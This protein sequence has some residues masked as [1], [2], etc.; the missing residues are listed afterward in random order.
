MFA[1]LPLLLAAEPIVAPVVVS[2]APERVA[3]S[4][5]RDPDRGSDDAIDLSDPKG[6]AVVSEVRRVTLPPGPVTIRFEGVASG[7]LPQTA[8]VVGPDTAE[9]NRD[10]RLL[11]QRGLLDAFTG[12]AMTLR[13]TDRATGRVTTE[14]AVLRSDA[15][16]LI[17]ETPRGIEAVKCSGLNQ[18]LLA[19]RLPAGL[20]AKPVLSVLT[21]DQPGG[22]VEVTLTY[23]ATR[24]D[25][26]ANYV[27]ELAPD[28]RHLDLLGWLTLAS[29][30]DTS[31]ADAN[32]SAIAGRVNKQ[33]A[34]EEPE[35]DDGEVYFRCWPAGTT[36]DGLFEPVPPPPPAPM[37][38][39]G[40][41][42]GDEEYGDI[43]VTGS[44]A[45]RSFSAAAIAVTAVQENL[46][47]LKLFR[48]P[49]PV[50]VAARAQKQVAF[51]HKTRVPGELVHRIRVS[52]GSANDAERVYFLRNTR[53][54]GLG[55]ALPTGQ[56]TLYQPG[57]EGRALVG[58][59]TLADK[60][61][62]EDIELVLG[63]SALDVDSDCKPA[64]RCRITLRNAGPD[65]ATARLEFDGD[66][67]RYEGL[68][69]DERKPGKSIVL[70]TVPANGTRRLNYRAIDTDD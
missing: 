46:G 25:W 29:A 14:R 1:L 19:P 26:Q 16:R 48:I 56:W 20:S 12:Q 23:I 6:F 70:V 36:S 34:E 59:A 65:A 43:V 17:V 18:T 53:A 27:A 39:P 35:E 33:A 58:Q 61:E 54:G 32:A 49:V 66:G 55:Q 57:P 8:I 3:V 40:Y 50:T 38:A 62:G 11:S 22:T 63:Q 68:H 2:T 13:R 4:L 5:Y 10:A 42:G 24:F 28:G 41:G 7:I 45:R 51:T 37:M 52:G 15:E 60:T 31:F 30:D 67:Y 64:E 21:R 47:D 44:L 9:K 69:V